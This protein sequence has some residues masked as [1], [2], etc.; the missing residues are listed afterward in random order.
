MGLKTKVYLVDD[1]GN[2]YMGI[3]VV[4][5]L[6]ELQKCGS[7]RAAA[8][9]LQLSYSKAYMMVCNLEASLGRE[10][11]V[12]RKGG[13]SRAGASLTPFGH[14][15]LKRYKQFHEDI[16]RAERPVF[17]EFQTDIDQMI[18]RFEK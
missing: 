7:L 3:G 9:D 14:A 5:L 15:F 6:E 13:V 11:I 17:E 12:R 8:A 1:K 2:K 10:V 4:W 18:G 16:K